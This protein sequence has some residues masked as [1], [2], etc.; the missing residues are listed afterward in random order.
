MKDDDENFVTIWLFCHPSFVA[1]T[2]VELKAVLNINA[3][4]PDP[5]QDTS[6]ENKEQ[7]RELTGSGLFPT[8]MF[9]NLAFKILDPD[10]YM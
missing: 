3:P 10:L 2:L 7:V 5:A 6:V 4:V 1:E 9:L 8:G